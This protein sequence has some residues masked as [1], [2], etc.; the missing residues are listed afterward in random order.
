M[1]EYGAKKNFDDI[2]YDFL[3]NDGATYSDFLIRDP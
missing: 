1:L 2:H 3:M